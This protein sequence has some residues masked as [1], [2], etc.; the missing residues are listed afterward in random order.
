L[1]FGP[2]GEGLLFLACTAGGLT[3]AVRDL[4]SYPRSGSQGSLYEAAAYLLFV[5]AC[6]G[7]FLW[8]G[9]L[10]HTAGWALM[11]LGPRGSAALAC[12]TACATVLMVVCDSLSGQRSVRQNV[13]G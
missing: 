13:L 11:G 5:A 7:A 6:A 9:A 12:G 8:R 3:T 1:L 2:A 4:V 10:A